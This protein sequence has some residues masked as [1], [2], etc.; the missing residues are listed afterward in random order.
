MIPLAGPAGT[1]ADACGADGWLA[2][3]SQQHYRSDTEEVV[4]RLK[5]LAEIERSFR[6]FKSEI[7]ISLECRIRSS[8]YCNSHSSVQADEREIRALSQN[9]KIF[10]DFAASAIRGANMR[11]E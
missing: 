11:I 8:R 10:Y 1:G 9:E 3:I 5:S 6:A 7:E 4:E 2:S